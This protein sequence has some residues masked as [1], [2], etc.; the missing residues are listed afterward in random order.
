[1]LCDPEEGLYE[2]MDFDKFNPA[3]VERFE[4]KKKALRQEQLAQ[5]DFG[6]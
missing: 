5:V 4:Q 3:E 1:M 2:D 6:K